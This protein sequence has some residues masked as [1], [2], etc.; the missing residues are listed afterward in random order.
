MFKQVCHIHL[1]YSTLYQEKMITEQEM[2]DLKQA[3]WPWHRLVEI[4]CTKHP[5]VVKR[6]AE[7]LAKAKH[8][9]EGMRLNGQCHYIVYLLFIR[10]V[11][12]VY[13]MS[14]VSGSNQIKFY[15]STL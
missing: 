8:N 12:Y 6:T 1:V 13:V 3:V 10:C 7:L 14:T 11:C 2:E 15:C 9:E 5:D 4:Q